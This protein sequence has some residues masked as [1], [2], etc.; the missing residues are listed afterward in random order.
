MYD[1]RPQRK[2]CYA[3]LMILWF[4]LAAAGCFIASSFL[5]AFPFILQSVGLLLLVPAIQLIARYCATRYLYRLATYEDGNVDLDVY[6]YRGGDKMQ[7]V[8]R[9]G[10][11]EITGVKA[12][13]KE[14]RRAPKGLR[15]YSYAP[16]MFPCEALVLS[17]T[18]ADG[19]CEVL[20]C[21]DEHMKNILTSAPK[22]E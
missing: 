16:D 21:P 2:N 5:P 14:N 17:V 20:I 12:L 8:C 18:N 13:T 3:Q 4:F 22:A 10:L 1:Y 15:R 11:E 7:L 9:V 19:D 6:A